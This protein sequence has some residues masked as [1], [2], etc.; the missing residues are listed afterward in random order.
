[1]TRRFCERC[2]G[3]IEI[4]MV[5]GSRRERCSECGTVFYSNPLPVA[6]SVVLNEDREVLL[7]RRRIEPHRGE[8]CLPTGFAEVGETIEDAALR[9][10]EEEAGI[11]GKV[12]RL[13]TARSL[14]SDFYGDLLFVCFEVEAV[15]GEPRPGDDAEAVGY[16]PLDGLPPLAFETHTE[17]VRMC[18]ALHRE[19]WAIQDSFSHLYSDEAEGMLSDV[20]VTLVEEEAEAI[21]DRW[22]AMIRDHPTTPAYGG[23]DLGDARER[24]LEALSHFCAWLQQREAG[25]AE[26][27]YERLG[28]LRRLEGFPLD[29]VL[30]AL[31]LLRKEIWTFARERQVLA[32]PLDVYRVMELSRRIVLFFDKALFHTTKGYLAA[33]AD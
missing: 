31:T 27:F 12:F 18:E 32:S 26:A 14:K 21:T 6:A 2:G 33:A 8:W 13:L 30:S 19:P 10:L 4:S 20:L 24:A 3:P 25:E 29:Q 11:V 22:L 1:M 9:E 23:I 17:A 5:E 16:F 7:I 28:A 15:G